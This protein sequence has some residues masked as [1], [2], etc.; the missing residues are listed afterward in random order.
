MSGAGATISA[1]HAPPATSRATDALLTT[2][3]SSAVKVLD[4]KGR[5]RQRKEGPSR[6]VRGRAKR[7]SLWRRKF[8]NGDWDSFIAA[9]RD[10]AVRR[11][12]THPYGTDKKL[13]EDAAS[14]GNAMTKIPRSL[15]ASG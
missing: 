6:G 9:L 14:K 12:D 5:L 10:A 4:L 3:L 11:K 1:T 15:R 8:S 2:G 13:R 7:K